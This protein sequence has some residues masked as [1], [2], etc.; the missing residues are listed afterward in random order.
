MTS[1]TTRDQISDHLLTPR[2]S[3]PLVIDYQPVQGNSVRSMDGRLLVD[4]I[5]RVGRTAQ[6]YGASV[7]AST[8]NVK[9]GANKPTIPELQPVLSASRRWTGPR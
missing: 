3:A 8:V 2:N 6:V 9:T 7:I 1:P 4:N 5:V